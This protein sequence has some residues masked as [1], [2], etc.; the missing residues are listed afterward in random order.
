ME[1]TIKQRTRRSRWLGLSRCSMFILA[2][3]GVLVTSAL[4]CPFLT[5]THEN[6]MPCSPT[7]GSAPQ[8]TF[9]YYL[10]AADMRE[11]TPIFQVVPGTVVSTVTLFNAMH[12]VTPEVKNHEATLAFSEELFLKMHFL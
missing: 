5:N 9:S 1:T 11:Y 10:A 8:C 4:A 2:V 12:V 3:T 6:A 7:H